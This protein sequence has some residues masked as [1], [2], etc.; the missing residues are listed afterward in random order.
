MA[1]KNTLN[2]MTKKNHYSYI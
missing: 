2:F 1:S